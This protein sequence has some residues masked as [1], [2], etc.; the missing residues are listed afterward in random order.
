VRLLVDKKKVPKMTFLEPFFIGLRFLLE[1]SD[2]LPQ[3]P[4]GGF[5]LGKLLPLLWRGLGRG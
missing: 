3:P 2:F 4:E 1:R 5:I